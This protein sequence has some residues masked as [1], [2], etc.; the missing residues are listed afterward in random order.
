[1]DQDLDHRLKSADPAR[2]T[3][4]A[5]DAVID[6]LTSRPTT[7][8]RRWWLPVIA[9][10]GALV[11]AGGLA[12]ATDLD[13]YLLSVPPFSTLDEGT[14]RPSAGLPYVPRGETDRGEQCTLYIDLGGLTD[15]E[16]TAVSDYWAA[17]DPEAFAAGVESRLDVDPT[18]DEEEWQAIQ[19]Q[20][21]DDLDEIVPG[22]S[23][24]TAAPGQPFSAGEPHLGAISRICRDDLEALGLTG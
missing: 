6:E 11:L 9:T 14:V 17:A 20:I 15:G 19:D 8:R 24:G 23:W 3:P 2:S 4:V 16:F 5:L 21:L 13:A 1:M 22:I 7:R 10:G 18:T 12:A